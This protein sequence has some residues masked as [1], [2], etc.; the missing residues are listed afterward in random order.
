MSQDGEYRKPSKHAGEAV[1]NADKNGIG[2]AVVVK[3]VVRGQGDQPA[4]SH[5]Q[6][7]EDLSGCIFPHLKH[8]QLYISDC[9]IYP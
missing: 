9:T 3:F 8:K 6:G 2:I 5:G 1:C 4:P 7:V